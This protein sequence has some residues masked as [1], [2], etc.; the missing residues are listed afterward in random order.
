M[1]AVVVQRCAKLISKSKVLKTDGFGAL[2]EVENSVLARSIFGSEHAKN[3]KCSDH[4]WTFNRAT[5]HYNKT[6]QIQLQL[7]QVVPGQ[8]VPGQAGGGSFK[9]ETLTAYRAEQRLCL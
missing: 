6:L 1:H 4:F 2:F 7:L 9:F 5:L 8:V 3:T